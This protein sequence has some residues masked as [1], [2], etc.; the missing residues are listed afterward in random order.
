VNVFPVLVEGGEDPRKY[1]KERVMNRGLLLSVL[2]CGLLVAAAGCGDDVLGT[3]GSGGGTTTTSTTGTGNTTTGTTTS[4]TGGSTS[5]GMTAATCADYCADIEA[6]CGEPFAQYPT[7]ESCA[8]ICPVFMQGDPGDTSMNTLECRAY[9]TGAAASGA[10]PHCFHAGPLGSGPDASGGCG[11]QRCSSFC[12]IAIAVCDGNDAQWGLESECMTDC[13]QMT[14]DVNYSTS[15]MAGD[16]LA[17]RMYHLSVA[18]DAKNKGDMAGKATHCGHI[19]LDSP[20]C[21]G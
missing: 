13:M 16:T 1:F 4:T 5:T 6:N 20:T 2:S 19:P 7:P 14:D 11:G 10:D 12:Q 15:E 17:C 18:A 8:E 3:G 9:H 21:G